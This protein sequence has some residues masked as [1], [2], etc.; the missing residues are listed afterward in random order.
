M[1]IL[2]ITMLDIRTIEK[3]DKK[4]MY[5][6][7]DNWPQIAEKAYQSKYKKIKLKKI[8]HIVF[9]GMGGSGTLGD[10]FL[11]IFS[12]TNI[13]VDVVKGYKLPKTVSKNTLVV[14]TSVSGNTSETISVLE[15]AI[16]N[17]CKII[18]FSS[19]GKIIKM[20]KKKKI[21]Y[22][23]IPK[24][25]NP[26]TS[27]VAYL[28]SMLNILQPIIPITKKEIGISINELKKTQKSIS[29]KN[30]NSNNLAIKL[31]K[32]IN[33][34]PVVYFPF[35]LGAV[36]IRFKNSL[37]E[38]SKM[39]VI[40]EDIIEACHNGIVAWENKS[41]DFGPILIQ[42]EDDNIKTKT[43]WSV[44]KKFFRI[45]KIKFEEVNSLKGGILSKIINLIYLL[46]Y[47]TIYKAVIDEVD[48]F[49]VES[50]NYIKK[51]V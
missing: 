13:Q 20:C 1:D 27:L 38:N 25:I 23:I 14:T 24:D 50:I 51:Y 21:E 35:G 4:L 9:S 47:V 40:I 32:S 26:R 39:H 8:D 33:N 43:H 6:V 30:L 16:K 12:C 48:P 3:F 17:N 22:R 2:K 11:S 31:A 34:I 49:P 10:I 44:L 28:Y 45:K 5:K 18:T 42:G 36:A 37:E 29:S 15:E 7:Y 46:D 41:K 19:G